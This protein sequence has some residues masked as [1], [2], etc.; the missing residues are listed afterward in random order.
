MTTSDWRDDHSTP[1]PYIIGA[2]GGTAVA[3]AWLLRRRA[4]GALRRAGRR[5]RPERLRRGTA[6]EASLRRLEDLVLRRLLD[7]PVLSRRGIDVG[8]ISAGIIELSGEVRT[9]VESQ[10]AVHLA[11]GEA[12]VHTV[13][14]R[15]EIAELR[16]SGRSDVP[17]QGASGRNVGMGRMRQGPQ[18][19][20]ARRDD[21]QWLEERAL[22][23]ADQAEWLDEGFASEEP[24]LTARG[25]GEPNTRVPEDELDNQDPHRAGHAR[26]TL[27]SQPQRFNTAARVGEAP[28]PGTEL[29]L[30]H[31]DLPVKPHGSPPR[32]EESGQG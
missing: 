16:R 30:E 3:A 19:E 20:P 27:D 10:Q 23:E 21:S 6:E 25:G 29:D 4:A 26:Y 12:G 13:L 9:R 11:E 1:L 18:T 8:A 17:H 28:K 2:A 7:D 22:R 5:L 14:N 32:P 15:M 24:Q 31:S